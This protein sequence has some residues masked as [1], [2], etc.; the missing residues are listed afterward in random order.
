ME[1]EELLFKV[2]E[3]VDTP[4][5]EED[6]GEPLVHHFSN[7]SAF[8]RDVYDK[9]QKSG[10]GL[11]ADDPEDGTEEDPNYNTVDSDVEEFN[12]L[13]NASP[14]AV[15]SKGVANY[16]KLFANDKKQLSDF[17]KYMDLKHV[18]ENK[19]VEEIASILKQNQDVE[20]G[21]N[22]ARAARGAENEGDP[23]DSNNSAG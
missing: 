22:S 7:M 18:F 9:F 20:D 5:Y 10:L 6:A 16:E 19:S 17:R 8:K 11:L 23:S 21:G 3:Q 13:F 12:N 1:K 4:T 14:Y 15:D 2:V